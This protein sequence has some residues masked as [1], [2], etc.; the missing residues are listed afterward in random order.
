MCGVYVE[1]SPSQPFTCDQVCVV[2]ARVF[3]RCVVAVERGDRSRISHY[4]VRS[5]S[6]GP[7][8]AGCQLTRK[9]DGVAVP[10]YPLDP[11]LVSLMWLESPLG[12]TAG[13]GP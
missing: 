3:A 1:L 11:R 2:E 10:H 8:D 4:E 7:S 13:F 5:L 12:R 9:E 6:D